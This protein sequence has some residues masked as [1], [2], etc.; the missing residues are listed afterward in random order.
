M[1]DFGLTLASVLVA[2][3]I[4]AGP[5]SPPYWLVLPRILLISVVLQLSFYY[6]NLY[7][8]RGTHKSAWLTFNLVH[9]FAVAAVILGVA[10]LLF[11]TLMIA[12]G[13]FFV[14]IIFVMLLVFPW[15]FFYVAILR[16]RGIGDNILIVGANGVAGEIAHEL[17]QKA[18]PGYHLVGLWATNGKVPNVSEAVPV[19]SGMDAKL[20]DWLKDNGVNTAVAA[21][22]EGEEPTSRIFLSQIQQ[23]VPEVEVRRASDFYEE[24]TGKVLLPALTVADVQQFRNSARR[25]LAWHFKRLIDIVISLVGLIIT[26]PISIITAIAIKITSRGPILFA[27]DRVGQNGKTFRLLKFR[28]MWHNAEANSGPVWAGVRDDRITTVGRVIRKFRVDEFPQMLNVLRGKMSFIGPRPERPHFVP[29][30]ENEIPFYG[31]RHCV[32]PGLTG[33]AQVRHYYTS[34]TEETVGKLQYDL[35]YIKHMSPLLDFMILLDTVKTIMF[36][37][38]AR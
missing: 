19:V 24:V 18:P 9:S 28:S 10:Y 22:K 31:Q 4:K 30:L 32:K 36:G 2:S 16:R 1:V 29:I 26:L 17:L 21:A 25:K 34:S 38:G 23:R 11:P 6:N 33:L 37:A 13:V 14:S 15:R 5:E 20:F 3:L 27:Q 35:Y 8:L 7:N 12:R